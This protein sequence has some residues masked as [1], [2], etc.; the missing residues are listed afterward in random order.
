[1]AGN[2]TVNKVN[3]DGTVEVTF[4]VDNVKQNLSG[5]NVLDEKALVL[6]I[7]E[8]GVAYESGKQLEAKVIPQKVKD[9]VGKTYKINDGKEKVS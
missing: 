1:M 6:Q 4:D 2:F 5:M 9:L 8:Y 3:V 7:A